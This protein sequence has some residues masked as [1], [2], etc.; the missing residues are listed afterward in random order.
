MECIQDFYGCQWRGWVAL[1]ASVAA[2]VFMFVLFPRASA[3]TG[4][5]KNDVRALQMAYTPEMF[6]GVLRGWGTPK[7][8]EEARG[9]NRETLR[10]AV[11]T[12]KRKNIRNLDIAFP[13]VY[14]LALGFAYAWLSGRRQP[15]ALDFV[16]FL[17]PFVAGLFDLIENAIHLYLLSGVNTADDVDAAVNAKK[18]KPSLVFAA[19]AFAHAKY[20]LLLVSAA[21]VLWAACQWLRGASGAAPR[22]VNP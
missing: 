2:L 21:A 6:V 14:A 4:S 5:K 10:N 13:F 12:M 18:F 9:E 17:T 3:K 1:V 16:L 19:S 22:A 11:G 20:L 15:T 8:E 7:T